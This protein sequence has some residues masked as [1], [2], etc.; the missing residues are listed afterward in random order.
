MESNT[1]AAQKSVPT[2][3]YTKLSELTQIAKS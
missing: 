1:K 2:A 3:W